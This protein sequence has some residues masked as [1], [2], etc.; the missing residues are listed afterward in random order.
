MSSRGHFLGQIVDDLDAIASQV[1]QR[2]AVGQNDLNR[3]LEDFFKEILN[4]V[5]GAN[6]RNLNKDRSN[7]PGLDRDFLSCVPQIR[8]SRQ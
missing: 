5:R 7:A 8:A 4:L 3:V 2:C 1:R 6:L